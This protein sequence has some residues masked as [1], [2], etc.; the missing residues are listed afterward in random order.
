M[1]WFTRRPDEPEQSPRAS[2]Q[3]ADDPS[4][5]DDAA[6][7]APADELGRRLVARIVAESELPVVDPDA[8][9]SLGAGLCVRAAIDT[10]DTVDILLTTR[11]GGWAALGDAAL[12]GLRR[13]P[14]PAHQRVEHEVH[15]FESEDHFGASRLLLHDELLASVGLTDRPFGTLVALPTRSSLLVHVLHDATVVHALHLMSRV[16]RAG[17][18]MPGPLSPHVYYRAESGALQQITRYEGDQ[19]Q[20]HVDGAFASAM[21]D[22]K[23]T[24]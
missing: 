14:A 8:G 1:A 12:A 13:L 2:A 4:V 3:R 6:P 19:L 15:V 16:A 9:P 22:A 18:D 23:L 17:Q 21:H 5:L 11:L 24:D 10:P 7:V 20:V